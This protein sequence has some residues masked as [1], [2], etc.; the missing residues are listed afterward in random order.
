MAGRV[1]SGSSG[2]EA[3]AG[4]SSA[5]RIQ[6]PASGQ[7]SS[8]VSTKVRVRLMARIL[9]DMGGVSALR[10]KNRKFMGALLSAVFRVDCL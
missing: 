5:K 8:P 9:G 3:A 4:Q 2:A 1:L 10:R 6:M 7:R